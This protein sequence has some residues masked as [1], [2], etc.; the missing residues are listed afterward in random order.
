MGIASRAARNIARRK[1]RVLLAVV[2]ISVSMA[3]MV[4]I[5][6]GLT[7]SQSAVERL[8]DQMTVNY[9][10]QTAEIENTSSLIE[11][12]NTGST[13]SSGTGQQGTGEMMGGGSGNSSGINETVRETVEAMDGVEA[14]IPYVSMP[15]GHQKRRLGLGQHDDALG[16]RQLLRK[17]EAEGGEL[18]LA[19]GA[20]HVP[21][22]R[23]YVLPEVRE[24]VHR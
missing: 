12:G 24:A 17:L 19:E 7:A 18:L 20:V 3:I 23:P 10:E 16:V 9:A 6:A 13:Y 22:E 15:Q 14:V 2:A 21:P 5:P 11:V 1:V 4:A 8:N